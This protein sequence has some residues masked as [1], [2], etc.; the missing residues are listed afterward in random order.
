MS[1]PPEPGSIIPSGL[2]VCTS[3]PELLMLLEFVFGGLVWILV[4]ASRIPFPQNQ[5]WVMFVSVFCFVITT[6][7]LILYMAGVQKR[8]S[9]WNA[10]D[11]FYHLIAAIFYLSIAVLEASDT[12]ILFVLFPPQ[13]ANIFKLNIAASVF[14]FLATLIYTIHAILSILRWKSASS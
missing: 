7:L 2:K 8:S 13:L 14:A 6:L 11:V 1:A 4:A 3:V 10:V 12:R 9:A 5:G